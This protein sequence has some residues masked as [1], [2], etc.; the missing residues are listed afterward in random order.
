MAIKQKVVR[1]SS[2]DSSYSTQNLAELL[3][4]GWLV[5]LSNPINARDGE[6]LHIEYILQKDE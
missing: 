6:T 5:V 1:T 4:K 2:E 3:D